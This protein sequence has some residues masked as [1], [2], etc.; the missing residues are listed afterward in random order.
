VRCSTRKLKGS[1]WNDHHLLKL[2]S[3]TLVLIR[4]CSQNLFNSPNCLN[5]AVFD[6]AAQKFV[7]CNFKHVKI[8]DFHFSILSKL[9]LSCEN[10]KI[11]QIAGGGIN[12]K[13]TDP[14]FQYESL[15]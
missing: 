2:N 12:S 10:L 14:V 1:N 4:L 15:V 5:A 8:T 11:S 3:C 6:A 13:I 7:T 9:L